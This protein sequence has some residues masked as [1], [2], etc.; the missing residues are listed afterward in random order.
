MQLVVKE[1]S[2][3]ALSDY[4]FRTYFSS[5]IYLEYRNI[6]LNVKCVQKGKRKSLSRSIM[7]RKICFQPVHTNFLLRIYISIMVATEP[8]LR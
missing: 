3:M 8:V 6:K 4:C 5:G 1:L 7:G 2:Y